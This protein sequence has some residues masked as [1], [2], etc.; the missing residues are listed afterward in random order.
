M[1]ATTIAIYSPS[2]D[3]TNETGII[4]HERTDRK[5]RLNIFIRGFIFEKIEFADFFSTLEFG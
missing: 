4:L 5:Y 3:G 2:I 1:R